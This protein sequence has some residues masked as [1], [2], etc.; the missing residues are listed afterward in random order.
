MKAISIRPGTS[1]IELNDFPEP[2]SQSPTQVKIRILEVGIC[3]T[4]REEATGGRADA[5]QGHSRLIIGHEMFGIVVETG[6]EV[7]TVAVGDF[8]VFS[9][10]RGCG[11]CKPCLDNRSDMCYTGNY[12]TIA[13]TIATAENSP[14]ERGQGCVIAKA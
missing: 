13:S 9:V 1:D 12:K 5:P 8:G 2:V 3:G 6:S 11:N 10:R 7:S 14:L 4:D